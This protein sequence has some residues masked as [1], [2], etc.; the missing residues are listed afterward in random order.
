MGNKSVKSH[1]AFQELLQMFSGKGREYV[2]QWIEKWFILLKREQDVVSSKFIDSPYD[3]FMKEN[4]V[5]NMV[6]NL[7]ESVVECEVKEKS[8]K[9]EII[10]LRRKADEV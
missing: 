5:H 6:D 2:D 7:M 3:T 10:A 4:L 9:A 8:Y 1:R